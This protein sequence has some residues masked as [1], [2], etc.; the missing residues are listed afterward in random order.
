MSEISL[1]TFM[2]WS[3]FSVDAS[4]EGRSGVG[5][6][7]DRLAAILG[8]EVQG[9]SESFDL[10]V[11]SGPF[12]G[13]WEVKAPDN[14]SEIRPGTEGITAFGPINK[15][16]RIALDELSEFLSFPGIGELAQASGSSE[17]YNQISKR[18]LIQGRI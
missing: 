6:G 7:E 18:Y 11:G 12:A 5:P 16:L 14:S 8:G 3:D 10:Q 2:N 13:K 15:T 9:Q 1:G 4:L 17:I